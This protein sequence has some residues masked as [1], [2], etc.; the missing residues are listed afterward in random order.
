M[1]WQLLLLAVVVPLLAGPLGAGVVGLA[2]SKAVRRAGAGLERC[3]GRRAH[4]LS[5]GGASFVRALN[6]VPKI[7]GVGLLAVSL[8]SSN[9]GSLDNR[10]LIVLT[11]V[12]M[13]MGGLWASRPVTRTLAYRVTSLNTPNGLAANATNSILVG[14]ASLLGLPLSTTHVSG[15]AL[16]GASHG[17][18]SA[19][20]RWRVVKDIVNRWLVTV[21]AA[22]MLSAV[23]SELAIGISAVI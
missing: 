17:D 21:P 11:T 16:V 5:A 14:S 4:S 13:V 18:Q 22:A 19:H 7:V 6:D 8:E 20:I 9:A 10:A 23:F 2:I 12:V 15:A 1:R 3:S